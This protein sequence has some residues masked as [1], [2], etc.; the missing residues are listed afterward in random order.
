MG[1]NNNINSHNKFN[2]NVFLNEKCKDA[3][4]ISDFVSQLNIGVKDL[5]ETGR[6]GFADGISKIFINGLNQLDI[7]NKPL[8]CNDSKREVLYIK[9]SDKWTKEEEGKP[10]LTKAIKEVASKNIKQIFEW[11]K[12]HSEY[13]DPTSK[14][15]DKY[16]QIVCESMSGSTKEESEKNYN[17]IIRKLA[18]E[19]V[20]PEI[21]K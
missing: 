11:Q 3:L 17:K 20:I 4:N 10:I 21:E 9:D 1:N 19:T 14:Q 2:I 15:N 16:L 5:E 13:N 6:L 12:L 7:Y 8:H 18:K